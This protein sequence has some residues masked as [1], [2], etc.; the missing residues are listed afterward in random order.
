MQTGEA[1][2]IDPALQAVLQSEEDGE[3]ED[4]AVDG[5]ID[6]GEGGGEV[7]AVSGRPD[8]MRR[9]VSAKILLFENIQ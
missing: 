5:S 3:S 8:L 7:A 1:G 4:T 6:S 9:S 2:A